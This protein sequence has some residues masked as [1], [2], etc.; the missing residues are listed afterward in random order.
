MT[1]REIVFIHLKLMKYLHKKISSCRELD[2]A[3][4]NKVN[5]NHGAMS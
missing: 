1:K 3:A 5:N 4:K 2:I